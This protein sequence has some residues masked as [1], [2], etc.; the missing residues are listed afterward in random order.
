M[1]R[2]ADGFDQAVGR[3]RRFRNNLIVGQ[4]RGER[5]KQSMSARSEQI[6]V[7]IS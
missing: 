7:R 4:S 5:V 2:H 6:G 1:R 3:R